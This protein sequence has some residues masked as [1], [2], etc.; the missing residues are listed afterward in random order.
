[1]KINR[2][3]G[4]TIYIPTKGRVDRQ[5][6]FKQLPMA[7]QAKTWFVVCPEEEKEFSWTPNVLVCHETG[8]PAARQY[9]LDVCM[10]RYAFFLDDD[11]RFSR[12]EENWSME[13]PQM[14][15]MTSADLGDALD[16]CRSLLKDYPMV[17][18]DARG[19]N[20]QRPEIHVKI[21]TRIMRAFGVDTAILNKE[22][23]R[24]DKYLFWEDFHVALSLLVRGYKNIV[25]TDYCNDAATNT[26]GGCSTYRTTEK[27]LAVRKLFL[28]EHAPFAT[29]VDKTAKSWGEKM[30]GA[31]ATV[32]DL[33]IYWQKAAASYVEF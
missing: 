21:N 29:A 3:P 9:A 25:T 19:G 11:L 8:V 27:L 4:M 7:W 31:G 6:T 22:K 30:G 17:G 32:P 16:W 1:M 14:R 33:K 2:T 26:P 15:K 23:I 12:R 24:F 13:Q 5:V 28:Q 10:T 20:N 18:L